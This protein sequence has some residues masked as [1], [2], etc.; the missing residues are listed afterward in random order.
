LTNTPRK[1]LL[2]IDGGTSKGDP[3]EAMA[4]HGFNG[5]EEEVVTIIANWITAKQALAVSLY[6]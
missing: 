1:E 4:Y 3:C 5:K 2:S 6:P